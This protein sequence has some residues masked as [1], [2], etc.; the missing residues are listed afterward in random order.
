M[1]ETWLKQNKLDYTLEEQFVNII[2]NIKDFG[3]FYL[4]EQDEIF[5]EEFNLVVEKIDSEFDYYLFKF[6]NKY[7]Y[8]PKGTENKPK[9]NLFKYVGKCV[10]MLEEDIP[11][12]GIHSGYEIL[13]G[14]RLYEE[15]IQKAKFYN[16]TT[17]GICERN[18]LAGVLVFQT[19]C[20]KAKIKPIIGEEITIKR[21]SVRFDAK[22]YVVN[23]EGWNNLLTIHKSIK[24]DNEGFVEED[25][26]LENGKGLVFVFNP[27]CSLNDELIEKYKKSFDAIFYQIDTVEW[28]DQE[29]DLSYLNSVKNYFANYYDIIPPILINDSYY[30]DKEDAHIKSTLNTLSGINAQYKSNDQYFKNLDDNYIAFERLFGDG[31]ILDQ[32]IF[33]CLNNLNWIKENCV[34]EVNTKELHLPKF[35]MEGVKDNEELFWSLIEKGV[36]EKLSIKFGKNIPDEYIERI[37]MEFDVI[38][39]G[40]FIDYF[41]ILWDIINWCHKNKILV[42]L[43]RGSVSGSLIS[44]LVNLTKVDPIEY[45]LLFERFMNSGR[46]TGSLPDVD[47]DFPQ[48]KRELVKDYIKSKYGADYFC[49]VGTYTTLQLKAAI[50]DLGRVIGI[51]ASTRNFITTKIEIGEGEDGDW[52][53]IFDNAVFSK[54]KSLIKNFVIK[55]TGLIEDIQLCLAQPKNVSVHASANIIVPKEKDIYH[56]MPLR[57]EG[58]IIIS[59]WEGTY[60]EKAGF[61]KEDL[62]GLQ[63]LDKFM[64]MIDLIKKHYNK[65][66]DIYTL[67]LDDERVYEMFTKGYTADIFQIGTLGFTSYSKLVKPTNIEDLI[68]M[69]ALFR[70]GVMGTGSHYD[71]VHLKEGKK[72]PE[73]DKHCEEILK[74]TFGIIIYQEQVMQICQKVAG[75]TLIEADDIR[76]AVG[77]KQQ[78]LLDSYKPKFID[79]AIK[80]DYSKDEAESLWRKLETFGSYG[81]NRSHSVTYAITG[82]ISMWFKVN[83]PLEFW[84]TALEFVSKSEYISRFISEMNKVND[85]NIVP[86]NIN[87]SDRHFVINPEEKKIYWSLIQIKEVGEVSTEVILKEREENGL[88]YSL[89]EFIKRV[90][91]K[92]VNKKVI[93]SLIFAGSFDEMENIK[94]PIKRKKLLEKYYEI[95]KVKIKDEEKN[96]LLGNDIYK[97]YWWVLKQKEVSGLGYLDYYEIIK[98]YSLFRDD[99]DKHID[100]SDFLLELNGILDNRMIAGI[101]TEIHKRDSKKREFAELYLDINDEKII[102][103]IWNSSW[104]K[105]KE[106]LELS[107]GKILVITGKVV[108]DSWKNLNVLHSEDYTEIDVLE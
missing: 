32:L 81:F 25:F 54:N 104:V 79:G 53:K 108:F 72:E 38:K 96:V 19:D 100:N 106:E 86:P 62:L 10:Q 95:A 52:Q 33:D 41:L 90:P 3:R 83:Y 46:L 70:P 29:K 36:E 12:I 58:D 87:Y 23:Y 13:N 40:G 47:I 93:E 14:S 98:E 63:Q 50:Q 51:D 76:K 4:L 84:T 66:I 28:N 43:G 20:K 94:T 85:A 42:G 73:Y 107:I 8:T 34:F 9:L 101:L 67:P 45:D 71:Y 16:Y 26:L 48:E 75:F 74:N 97:K 69:V 89:E 2:I 30:L 77:K 68:A 5:G 31:E 15:W 102:C 24:I 82:Y 88:F 22:V 1:L 59:E 18:T 55:Y 6:G 105:F 92:K 57:K 21:N 49:S 64:F 103:T 7:Y 91:K 78:D 80:N 61:L 17:L 44:Y 39:K 60:L 11:Y 99:I 65:D 27:D 37:D 35:E 56:W